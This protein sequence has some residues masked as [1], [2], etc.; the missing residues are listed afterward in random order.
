MGIIFWRVVNRVM[1][2][3]ILIILLGLFFVFCVWL[4]YFCIIFC[5]IRLI[6][7]YLNKLIFFFYLF[8]GNKSLYIYGVG[9]IEEVKREG[10]RCCGVR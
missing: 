6:Y 8:G 4:K 1:N 2:Y 7:F 5:C 3:Y 10:G 9:R